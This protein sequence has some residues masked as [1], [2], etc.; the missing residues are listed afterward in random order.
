[1][2]KLFLLNP[3][4]TDKKRDDNIRY[5]CPH[6]AQ[7]RGVLEYYP[8]LKELLEVVYV[9]FER[10]RKVLVDLV[11]EE[12]QGCPNLLIP[13]SEV[14]SGDDLSYFDSYGDYYFTN[15]EELIYRYLSEK[16]GIGIPH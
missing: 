3:D 15:S 9:D 5:F 13:K 12:N 1:M 4:F 10:P 11:G 16:Y 14:S 6:A 2:A 7:M 8:K